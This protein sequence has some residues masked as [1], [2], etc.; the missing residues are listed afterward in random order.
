[1]SVAFDNILNFRDVGKTVNSYLGRK[2]VREGVLYRSARPDNASPADRR[3]LVDELGIRTVMDLRSNTE[4][5]MRAQ[6]SQ[7]AALK[8][9]KEAPAP[10]QPPSAALADS[11]RIPGLRYREVKVTGRRFEKF[12]LSQLSWVN[13]FKLIVLFLLG[14]RMQ[15]VSLLGREVML[16]RGLVGM[17]FVTM[18]ESGAEIAEALRA[19]ISPASLPALVHCTQGKDRTGLVVTLVLMVLDVPT[20]AVAHDY[21]LSQEGLEA[22]K[23]ARLEEI[24]EIGLTPE[25]GDAPK[26]FVARMVDYVN[27]EYGGIDGYL[28]GI[29]FESSERRR[30]VEV[31]GA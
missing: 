4:H 26:D 30:L 27:T 17:G 10:P 14:Y 29:G 9:D 13:Y 23:E 11:A 31:L 22:E 24:G 21:V 2:L 16:P 25:W 18:D 15:A 28:D 5:L 19:F 6:K 20:D 1:M 3:K 8:E 12:L 7:A